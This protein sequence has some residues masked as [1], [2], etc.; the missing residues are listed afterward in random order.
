MYAII[1]TGGKQYRVAKDDVIDVELLSAEPGGE[2][3]FDI[4]FIHDGS[5]AHVGEPLVAG[6]VVKGQV[7]DQVRGPKIVSMKYQPR[8]NRPRKWGHRQKY[9]R[10]KITEI[11]S[12]KGA[13][14]K[15]KAV[16]KEEPKEEKP[17]TEAKP[18]KAAKQKA[19]AEA[20][21]KAKKTTAKTTAKKKAKGE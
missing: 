2:V 21:P 1:K 10:V 13:K 6:Y 20:K 18:K 8:E 17:K 19:K 3:E 16:K 14:A 4:L 11:G 15:P 12:E 9:L 5:S 7:L